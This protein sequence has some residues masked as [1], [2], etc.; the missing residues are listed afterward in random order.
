MQLA[1]ATDKDQVFYARSVRVVSVKM[2]SSFDINEK[3]LEDDEEACFYNLCVRKLRKSTWCTK[4]PV[5]LCRYTYRFKHTAH[6]MICWLFTGSM[7][8]FTMA[9]IVPLVLYSITDQIINTE[10]VIDS[11]S[12]P[13]Y[14]LWHTNAHGT[15]FNEAKVHMDLYYFDLQNHDDVLYEAA[16]PILVE[17]GPYAYDE[18]YYR[19]DIEWTDDGDTVSY[20]MQKYYVFNQDRTGPGLQEFDTILMPYPTVV[21]FK[22]V[23]DEIP[24]EANEYFDQKVEQNLTNIERNLI[25]DINSLVEKVI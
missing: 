23:I 20:F 5:E 9:I 11:T 2:M 4:P 16:K 25:G 10:V 18:Y 1:T 12:A 24:P 8:F 13:N 7:V 3:P 15:G 21:G 22:Y 6:R 14:D 19:F 17:K